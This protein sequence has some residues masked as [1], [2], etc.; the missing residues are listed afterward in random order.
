MAVCS[1]NSNPEAVLPDGPAA[2]GRRDRQW[3]KD[4][5]VHATPAL[6]LTHEYQTIVQ[7]MGDFG[8][9]FQRRYPEFLN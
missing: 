1:S 3:P 4:M 7:R 9:Q 2:R 8:S 5:L 6:A